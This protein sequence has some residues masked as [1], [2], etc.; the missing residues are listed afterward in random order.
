MTFYWHGTSL[1]HYKIKIKILNCSVQV[2]K[3]TLSNTML[4]YIQG[5][6]LLYLLYTFKSIQRKLIVKYVKSKK[7]TS[8]STEVVN[9][10][11][12]QINTEEYVILYPTLCTWGQA[13]FKGW[14][15]DISIAP[16]NS[17]YMSTHPHTQL[18][19][20]KIYPSDNLGTP[21][22]LYLIASAPKV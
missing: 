8:K 1:K 19:Q 22:S 6:L 3:I 15:S 5:S 4:D 21:I 16:H 7:E 2:N 10:V 11:P 12:N 13:K 14:G 17:M 18:H 20:T 9:D